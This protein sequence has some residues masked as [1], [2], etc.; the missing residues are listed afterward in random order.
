MK[1][2]T[3]QILIDPN[4]EPVKHG[5]QAGKEKEGK[6]LMIGEWLAQ[7]L[8]MSQSVPADKRVRAAVLAIRLE[9]GMQ[10]QDTEVALSA[11][12]VKLIRQVVEAVP[13]MPPW[14]IGAA[15]YFLDPDALSEDERE[16]F[17]SVYDGA[18]ANPAA[19]AG[20]N[21][22]GKRASA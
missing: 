21:G 2:D 12:D 13:G 20:A 1:F 8:A 18:A 9:R 10:N 17:A 19:T 11:D 14:T 16:T 15:T 5:P 7:H 3:T 22:L 6:M 4:G